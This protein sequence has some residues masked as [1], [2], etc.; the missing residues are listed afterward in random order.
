MN[1]PADS[2]F[3][4]HELIRDRWSPV[5]FDDRPISREMLGSLLEA[6]RWAPSSYNEQPWRYIVAVRDDAAEFSKLMSCLAEA[7]AVWAKNASVLILAVASLKF[8]RNG[9]PNRHAQHDVGLA[10]ENLVLQAAALGLAGHQMAG[11]DPDKCR[12][13]YKIPDNFEPL[14]MIAVGYHAT[15]AGVDESLRRREESPRSRRPLSEIH[16]EGIW[17]GVTPKL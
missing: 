15:G 5:A 10:N 17:G 2:Q 6:A 3:P 4:L 8:S 11:F 14:T 9:K 7:N 1:S 12:A 13:L 16:F